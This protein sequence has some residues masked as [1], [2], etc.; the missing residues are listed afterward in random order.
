MLVSELA[1][2]CLSQTLRHNHAS[3]LELVQLSNPTGEP[4]DDTYNAAAV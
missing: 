4:Y 2:S 1:W 3:C